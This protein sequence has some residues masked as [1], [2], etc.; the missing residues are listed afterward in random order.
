MGSWFCIWD[1]L[2]NPKTRLNLVPTNRSATPTVGKL[3][4]LPHDVLPT[5]AF[6]AFR[7]GVKT[8]FGT[9]TKPSGH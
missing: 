2:E 1:D 3:S 8:P 7:R 6:D 9:T 4:L 5:V